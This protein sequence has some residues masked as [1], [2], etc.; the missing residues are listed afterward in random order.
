MEPT[1]SVAVNMSV[2]A[3]LTAIKDAL[4]SRSF[5]VLWH[6]NVPETL[7]S[8]GQDFTIPFHIL[9]VC[10]PGHAKRALETNLDVGFFLPCKVVVYARNGETRVGML[11]PEMIIGLLGEERLAGLA[12]EVE[13]II[14]D[15]IDSLAATA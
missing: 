5:G 1:Y 11:R 12:T 4:A 2:D 15:A 3:A 7:Q 13:G 10:N 6:L 14:R 9:E 8:K